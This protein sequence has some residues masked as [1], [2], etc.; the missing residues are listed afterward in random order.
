[1][2]YVNLIQWKNMFDW[3]ETW[4]TALI[5]ATAAAI[6]AVAL[7]L[8]RQQFVSNLFMHWNGTVARRVYSTDW[9]QSA[10][11]LDLY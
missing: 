1:M 8:S 3:S 6:E 11:L 5:L 10:H 2:N 4:F 9:N 7:F